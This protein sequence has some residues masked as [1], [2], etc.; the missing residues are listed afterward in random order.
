MGKPVQIP[1]IQ[2]FTPYLPKNKLQKISSI[3]LSPIIITV[4]PNRYFFKFHRL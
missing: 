3:L 4:F 1:K 2:T